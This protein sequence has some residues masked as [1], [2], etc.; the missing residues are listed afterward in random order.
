[1]IISFVSDM[2]AGEGIEGIF[3]VSSEQAMADVGV[4][5]AR[6]HADDRDLVRYRL[7]HSATM[8]TPFQHQYRVMHPVHG[9]IWVEEHAKPE[10]LASGE[11][12]WHGQVFDI[13]D[14]NTGRRR[15]DRGQ[16]R[17]VG[18]DVTQ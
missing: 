15:T 5:F 9:Q 2:S 8:L 4:V 11:I 18:R 10:A 12:L 1:M 6:M 3:G 17:P 13:T 14:Q 7:Q 16:V